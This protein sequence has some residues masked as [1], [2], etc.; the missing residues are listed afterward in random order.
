[1]RAKL[2][3]IVVI[4]C[5]IAAA[6]AST[7]NARS[8]LICDKSC[9]QAIMNTSLF[10]KPIKNKDKPPK[11]NPVP[12]DPDTLPFPLPPIDD[13]GVGQTGGQGCYVGLDENGMKI[14]VCYPDGGEVDNTIIPPIPAG[15]S[16]PYLI[17][18][19]W[20]SEISSNGIT[21]LNGL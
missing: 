10:T 8:V 21:C 18:G 7:V 12:I 2:I 20:I 4:T 15:M 17:D 16:C 14:W 6:V 11:G 1:V 13:F 9:I 19:V 5:F 3:V